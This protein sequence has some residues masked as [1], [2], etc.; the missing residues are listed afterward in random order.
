MP[1]PVA[2]STAVE[3][4]DQMGQPLAWVSGGRVY[5]RHRPG[6][7]Y[8]LLKPGPY[9]ELYVNGK[10]STGPTHVTMADSIEVRA[11]EER[12]AGHWEV[13]VRNRG[14]EAVIKIKPHVL[15][16]RELTPMPPAAVLQL[17]VRESRECLPP[18]SLED[19]LEALSRYG[20]VYGVDRQ[21]CEE[22]AQCTEEREITIARGTPPRPGDPGTVELFFS[23]E[24]RTPVRPG[25]EEQV[26]FR[27]RFYF[28]SVEAGVVLARKIPPVPG[29]PGHDVFGNV[30]PP[31]AT[32]DVELAAGNGVRLSP[33]GMEAIAMCAGRPVAQRKGRQVR[34]AI[35]EVLEVAGDVALESGN[36][37]FQ[38]DV[39]IAGNVMERMTVQAGGYVH[40]GGYVAGATVQAGGPLSISGNVLSSLVVAGGASALTQ[41]IAPVFGNLRRRLEELLAAIDQVQQHPAFRQADLQGDPGPLLRLLLEGKFRDLPSL[42]RG[43]QKA[44]R[45]LPA[46]LQSDK[47]AALCR[48]METALI[49]APLAVKSRDTLRLLAEACADMEAEFTPP[50]A[51][52]ADL[53]VRYALNSTLASTGCVKVMGAGCYNT[54]IQAGSEVLVVRSYRGGEIEA[55]SNVRIGELGSKAGVKTSVKVPARATVTLDLAWE[56]TRVQVG[57]R[58]H[59]FDRQ[60]RNVRLYLDKDGELRLTYI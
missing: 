48:Q 3:N 8:P 21:A 38:G 39:R 41:E 47:L 43:L 58:A 30:L 2:V 33:D 45:P 12:S 34:L 29:D 50:S 60:E 11:P 26:D 6:G 49:H 42:V 1:E 23:L 14:L 35:L 15:V 31:P 57:D 51:D 28:T 18:A 7:P 9:I 20:I 46:E 59:H 25:E 17:A 16:K 36:I 53:V 40:I 32:K 5:V 56:N 13:E 54:R 55:G 19:I 52:A 22:A 37:T 44:I 24:D 27:Q 4:T 10:L